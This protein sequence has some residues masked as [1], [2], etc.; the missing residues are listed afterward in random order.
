[1]FASIFKKLAAIDRFSTELVAMIRQQGPVPSSADATQGA[2]Q[3]KVAR[4]ADRAC[5]R[6]VQFAR[7]HDLGFLLSAHLA[8][9]VKWGLRG[10][11]YNER[12]IEVI[13]VSMTVQATG[14]RS[15]GA[16]GR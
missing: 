16:K 13:C 3:K 4:L 7:D 8:N 5:A 2:E 11:G 9:K 15:V 10:H 6:A 14:T 12:F 1:M